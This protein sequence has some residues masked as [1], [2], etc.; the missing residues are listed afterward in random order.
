MGGEL[1]KQFIP[2]GGKPVLMHTL[3]AFHHWDST[4]ELITVIPEEHNNY[5]RMLC[6]EL[7]C[8]VEHRIVFGG[9]TR[10]HSVMN[11]LQ[12]LSKEGLIAVH[13]GVRPMIQP[14]VINA[15]FAA[16][17]IHGAAVPVIPVTDSIRETDGSY[18]RPLNRERLRIVQTPQ[19]FQAKLLIEAY[20]QTYN[21]AFTDDASVVEHAGTCIHLVDGSRDNL[22][23]T[24]PIDILTAEKLMTYSR[25]S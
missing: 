10:F 11:A 25:F 4:A 9:H 2:I 7:D 21:E 3:L 22:K 18:N 5:W 15:C 19:V 17:I 12:S 14:D 16:A 13:D 1:P 20:R 6:R 23:I 8:N 24:T